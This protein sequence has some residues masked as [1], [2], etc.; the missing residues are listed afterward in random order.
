MVPEVA[1]LVCGLLVRGRY[2]FNCQP[3]VA[4]LNP[5]TKLVKITGV[6]E[7]PWVLQ[8]AYDKALEYFDQCRFKITDPLY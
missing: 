8:K 1:A 6:F 7:T 4:M 3:H 2:A 5:G